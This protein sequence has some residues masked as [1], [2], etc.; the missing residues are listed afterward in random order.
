V[1]GALHA[2][3]LFR[4]GLRGL[5]ESENLAELLVERGEI[6]RQLDSG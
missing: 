5:C 1:L 4:G 3:D 2:A 6:G